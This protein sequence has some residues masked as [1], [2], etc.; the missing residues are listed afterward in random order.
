VSSC[1]VLEDEFLLINN[2]DVWSSGCCIAHFY[3][4]LKTDQLCSFSTD[5][6]LIKDGAESAVASSPSALLLVL[7]L[8]LRL[9]HNLRYNNLIF[10]LFNKVPFCM[11]HG[12]YLQF[13]KQLLWRT[14]GKELRL[15]C[16]VFSFFIFISCTKISAFSFYNSLSYNNTILTL[17]ILHTL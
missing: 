12:T 7:L 1:L 3:G 5:V 6:K 2:S 13:L 17:F 10:L 14:M 9:Q 11:K 8:Q 16:T 15:W 4:K